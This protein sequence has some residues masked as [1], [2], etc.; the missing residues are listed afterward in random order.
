MNAREN[1]SCRG[2]TLLELLIVIAIIGILAAILL[3]ALA[4][5][6]ETARRAS[7]LMNL[8]QLGT[9]LALYAQESNGELPWSGGAGNADCLARLAEDCSG[10]RRSFAC[11]SDSNP[12]RGWSANEPEP[13]YW[14]VGLNAENSYRMSYD[15]F[16]AYTASPI[17]LPP[18]ERPIPKVPVMWD[19]FGGPASR[20]SWSPDGPLSN[21]VPGGGNVLWLDGSVTFELIASWAAPN[22]P[23]RPSGIVFEGLLEQA[24][25]V[26]EEPSP[27]VPRAPMRNLQR[28][29]I[30]RRGP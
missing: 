20:A 8:S 11:P 9:A 30:R 27:G 23:Y 21:H 3:P 12:G 17:M 10:L 22:L 16:G 28:R 7:C 26:S 4:R 25:R 15:Y 14:G 13:V 6:R 18:P 1:N 19:L 2:F 5:M 29:A 24:E